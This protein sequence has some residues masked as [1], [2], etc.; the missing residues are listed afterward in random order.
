MVLRDMKNRFF[1]IALDKAASMTGKRG[2]MLLL[3]TQLGTKLKNTD[4][5]GVNR[6]ALKT[7]LYTVGRLANAYVRG[8]YRDISWKTMLSVIASIL[9]FVNPFDLLPDVIPVTGLTDDFGVL[10]WV[11]NSAAGEMQKFL[12]WEQSQLPEA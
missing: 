5:K 2:R 10:L 9:Y 1:A 11:Y 3:L 12:T 7:K 6:T 8:H 4:W